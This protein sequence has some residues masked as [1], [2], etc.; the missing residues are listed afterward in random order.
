VSS[1]FQNKY[2]IPTTRL[3]NWNYGSNGAYFITICTQNRDHFF[4]HV[5]AAEMRL[6]EIGLLAERHWK[7]IPKHFPYIEL[8]NFVVM[9][10][11]IHGIIIMNK[12]VETLHC[13]VSNPNNKNI[14]AADKN[15]QLS[16]IAPK[17][18]SI[19]S[20]IRSYKSFVSKT[21][22]MIQPD[23]GWQPRFYDH[24]IRNADSFNN[25][26]NYIQNNPQDWTKDEFNSY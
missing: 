22:K 20:V 7:N 9:P 5:I 1:K 24:I 3:Q 21:A 17:S 23:F 19:S 13:N 26:Q 14:T 25:I 10:N 6:N 8:G 12:S 18:G 15:K 2:R 4:G 16:L 11:H